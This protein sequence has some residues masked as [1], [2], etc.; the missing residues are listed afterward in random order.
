MRTYKVELACMWCSRLM[1]PALLR[2]EHDLIPSQYLNQRC[3][4][5]G[6]Q[7]MRTGEVEELRTEEPRVTARDFAAKRGRRSNALIEMLKREEEA[8]A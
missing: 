2:S 3:Q 5:C 4:H 7:P 6:G 1:E 8:L